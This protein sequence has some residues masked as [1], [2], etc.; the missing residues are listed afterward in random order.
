ME[1]PSEFI[2]QFI[3]LIN[4]L[5]PEF[6]GGVFAVVILLICSA[7]I[8]GSEVAYFSLNPNDIVGLQEEEKTSSQRIVTLLDRPRYLL[9][10]ILI[11]NNFIN[12]FII[13]ISSVAVLEPLFGYLGFGQG[14]NISLSTKA[15]KFTMEVGV[16]TFFLVLFGE[17]APK[18]YASINN[19]QLARLMSRPLSFLKKL[20]YLPSQILVKSTQLIEKRLEERSNNETFVSLQDID[21]AIELT[22]K[23]AEH[24]EQEIDIL[25]GI[26]QFGNISVSQV[27]RARVDVV[28]LDFRLGFGEVLEVVKESGYSRFPVYEENI[29]TIT[30]VLY[31]KELLPHLDETDDFEWQVKIRSGYFVPD[32]KK[33]DD[34]LKE[35]QAKKVHM[36]IVVDEYGGTSGIVTLED[37]MEEVIGEI[38]DEFDERIDVD[39]EQIDKYTYQ[40][41]GKTLLNDVCR[42]C[43][44]EISTFDKVKGEAESIAGLLLELS[45][46]MPAQGEEIE[47]EGF[48]LTVEKV[49]KRRIERIKINIPKELYETE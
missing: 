6:I 3:P 38:Q 25:K 48:K 42:L 34:L 37:I 49:S 22:V 47:H 27:M 20:F 41:E 17:V 4:L 16:V 24:A 12:I 29:D 18:V 15:L 13:I 36:A 39:Y 5:T 2:Y 23:D 43:D 8:S 10:T 35:F 32:T 28:A 19:L 14:E 44:I 46:R 30:G 21:Q 11:T 40:F 33:I 45:G 1:L 26:V 9:A 7:L 31:A